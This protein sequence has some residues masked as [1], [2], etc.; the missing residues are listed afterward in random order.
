M[1]VAR[2]ASRI[3]ALVDRLELFPHLARYRCLAAD[4]AGAER[5][6]SRADGTG[7]DT[8]CGGHGQSDGENDPKRGARGYDGE[9]KV[10]GRKRQ[11]LVDTQG[12]ILHVRVHQAGLQ[13]HAGG[14]RLLWALRGRF[15]RMPLIWADSGDAKGGFPDWVTQ[16]LGWRVEIVEHPW[17]GLR[18]VWAPEGATIDGEPIRPSGFHVLPRRWMVE[19]TFAWKWVCSFCESSL[20]PNLHSQEMPSFCFSLCLTLLVTNARVLKKHLAA[21]LPPP[22]KGILSNPHIW[23]PE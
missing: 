8:E 23:K 11:G 17:S 21:V 14:T 18:G 22:P 9:K 12:L 3:S 19:R 13:D 2:G 10:K 7:T 20:Q 4:D 6:G 16:K 15:P 1:P 5:A